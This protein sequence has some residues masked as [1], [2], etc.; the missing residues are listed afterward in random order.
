MLKKRLALLP[1]IALS[2]S[3]LACNFSGVE[4]LNAQASDLSADEVAAL[5]DAAAQEMLQ[6]ESQVEPV[7]GGQDADIVD[8]SAD[9]GDQPA[10]PVVT[11]EPE[12]VVTEEPEPAPPEIETCTDRAQFV[13]DVT[14]EDGADFAPDQDLTKTWRL[15]NSGTCTWTSSY[16][17]VF[18]HGDQMG[19]PASQALSGL[20]NPG[21]TVDISV[22]LTAPSS[23]GGYK[24]YWLLRNSEDVL[25][26]IGANANVAF[27]VEIEVLAEDDGGSDFPVIEILPIPMFPVF[28]SSGSGQNLA[29]GACFDLDA[30]SAVACSSAAAGFKYH[31]EFEMV[32]FPPVPK[33]TLEIQPRSGA[34]FALFGDDIP[35]G[36][37]CQASALSVNKFKIQT[38]TYCYQTEAGKYGRLTVVGGDLASMTFDWATYTYP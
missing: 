7:V 30:G 24:G 35:N 26:G 29:S 36:N 14:V 34:R 1:V 19:G 15:R 3:I 21:D 32:G 23:E 2:L 6:D 11:E 17:L 28:V 10:D 8:S 20:V 16:D 27:W 38:K 31:A 4:S 22:D 13:T 12:P 5:V 33:L 37:E 25:F 9:A 18:D